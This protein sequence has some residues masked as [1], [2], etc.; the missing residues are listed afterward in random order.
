MKLI[1]APEYYDSSNSSLPSVF[2]GGGITN[3]KLWQDDLIQELSELNCVVFNPRRKIFDINDPAQSEIQ[4][5]WEHKYLME[6]Q[7]VIFY[8]SSETLCPITLFELGARLMS[9]RGGYEQSIYIYCE[10][11][12]QRKFD[13][14]FQTKLAIDGFVKNQ[15]ILYK[16][17]YQDDPVKYKNLA[18]RLERMKRQGPIED[19]YD[20]RCFSDYSAFVAQLQ[21]RIINPPQLVFK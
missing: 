6:S 10:P 19:G 2:L 16:C 11:T 4:I 21:I 20:V 14:E 5:L 15:E 12:Y 17:F 13:V 3:V 18:D 7:I 8:F 1:I 9:N